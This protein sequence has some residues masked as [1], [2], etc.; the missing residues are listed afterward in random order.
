M[1]LSITACLASVLLHEVAHIA[2]AS[3]LG[4]R[5]KRV[6]ISWKGPYIVRE[7]GTPPQNL[8]ISLAGP[9]ANAAL[10][11]V[12]G[13]FLVNLLLLVPNLVLRHSDGRR[14]WNCWRLIARPRN[15]EPA[16]MAEGNS[17]R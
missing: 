4:V 12:P 15:A 8:C 3:A 5:I 11:F 13:W 2:T 17:G 14:A 10:L 7:A 1:D 9:L 6:G 16:L